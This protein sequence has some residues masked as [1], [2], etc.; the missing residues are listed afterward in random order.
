[1]KRFL[2]ILVVSVILIMGNGCASTKNP[3]YKKKTQTVRGRDYTENR[4]LMLLDNK[5][6]GKNKYFYSKN[7]QRNIHRRKK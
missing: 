3:Y 7:N 6:L 4:G 5:Q 2:W 1:M